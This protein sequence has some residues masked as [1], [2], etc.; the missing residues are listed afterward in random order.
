MSRQLIFCLIESVE[1]KIKFYY[2]F[3]YATNCGIERRKLWNKVRTAANIVADKPWIMLGDFNVT[4]KMEEYSSGGSQITSEMQ[5][6]IDCANEVEMEDINSTG[7]FFTWI[8]SPSKPKTNHSATVLTIPRS[9]MKKRKYFR[10]SNYIVDKKVFLPTV[11]KE[12]KKDMDGYSMYRVVQKL[13]AIKQ[14]MRRLN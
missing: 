5:E 7:L 3:I 2:N 14:P 1:K 8:K 6:L 4:M 12:W 13:K 11:E 10:F 9:L